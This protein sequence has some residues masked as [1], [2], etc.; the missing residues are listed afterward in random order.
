MHTLKTKL[1]RQCAHLLHIVQQPDVLKRQL[2]E[3][4]HIS[5]RAAPKRTA[6]EG[7]TPAAPF[8]GKLVIIFQLNP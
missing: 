4:L 6:T 8:F 2:P 3:K 7:G 1:V 5:A